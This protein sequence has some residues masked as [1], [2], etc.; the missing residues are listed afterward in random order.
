[1]YLLSLISII[2]NPMVVIFLYFAK[3]KPNYHIKDHSDDEQEFIMTG[4]DENFVY[5]EYMK[6][7]P[8]LEE[9]QFQ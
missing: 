8:P 6:D 7:Y 1:M 2:W 3:D 9:N 5:R 4:H